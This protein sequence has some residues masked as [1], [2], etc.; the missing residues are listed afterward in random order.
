MI[1][2]PD[3]PSDSRMLGVGPEGSRRIYVGCPSVQTAPDGSRPIVWMTIEMINWHPTKQSD[4]KASY[5][6]EDDRMTV[7]LMLV[8]VTGR[9][10]SVRTAP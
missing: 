10:D 6:T 8:G 4:G 7:R 5:L 1:G 2:A 9:P 3:R